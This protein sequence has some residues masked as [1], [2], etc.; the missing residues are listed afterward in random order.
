MSLFR[1]NFIVTWNVRLTKLNI[2]SG[3]YFTNFTKI[4]FPQIERFQVIFYLFIYFVPTECYIN[5]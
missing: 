1:I 3:H 5:L 2:Q 4:I